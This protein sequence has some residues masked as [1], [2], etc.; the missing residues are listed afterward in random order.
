MKRFT[1]PVT[2]TSDEL[3]GG[4]V[5]TF[6]DVPEAITQ[7]DSIAESLEEAAG[8]LEAAI[9]GRIQG[10]MNIPAPSR[11]QRGEKMVPV[12][13][14]TAMKATLY[15]AMKEAHV[16]EEELARH[17]HMNENEVRHILDPHRGT[18]L[19][20]IERALSVL[21]KRVELHVL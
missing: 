1:Y 9:A 13:L 6:R 11:P 20:T 18:K 4:F 3:D 5:I 10:D 12:P 15:M 21:G 8:A 19:P 14:Q 7:G 2:L 17:L 16:S